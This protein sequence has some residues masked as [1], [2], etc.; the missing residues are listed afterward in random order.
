M[1][2]WAVAPK[3]IKFIQLMINFVCA[4]AVVISARL[5]TTSAQI[6]LMLASVCCLSAPPAPQ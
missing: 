1:G 5:A 4:Q 3:E 6:R 2:D